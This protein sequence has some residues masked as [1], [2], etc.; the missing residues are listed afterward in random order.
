MT[1]KTAAFDVSTLELS[2]CPF[3]KGKAAAHYV[4]KGSVGGRSR[5]KIFAS[6]IECTGCDVSGHHANGSTAEQA[7]RAS[8]EKWNRRA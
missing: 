7:C 2:D 1:K 8:A 4:S 6:W 5:V 3:C